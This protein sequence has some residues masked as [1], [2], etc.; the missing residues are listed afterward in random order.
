MPRPTTTNAPLSCDAAESSG[1]LLRALLSSARLSVRGDVVSAEAP[2]KPRKKR[3]R[4]RA[5]T[6]SP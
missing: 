5:P 3:S 6:P 2:A 4:R 1:R